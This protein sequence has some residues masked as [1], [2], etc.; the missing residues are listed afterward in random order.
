MPYLSINIKVN[1]FIQT[2]V[3]LLLK[4]LRSCTNLFNCKLY[5]FF[6]SLMYLSS[7]LSGIRG[8]WPNWVG[9]FTH[10]MGFPS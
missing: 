10:F 8:Y 6:N 3:F 5:D 9:V 4:K 7:G 2:I 1:I